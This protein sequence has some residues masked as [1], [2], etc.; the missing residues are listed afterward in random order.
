MHES[1][2]IKKEGRKM[3]KGGREL[4]KNSVESQLI[5]NNGRDRNPPFL[6]PQ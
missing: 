5:R 1:I 3:R 4:K 6:N 2:M